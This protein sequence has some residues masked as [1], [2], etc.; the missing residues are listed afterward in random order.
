MKHPVLDRILILLCAAAAFAGAAGIVLLLFG[1]LSMD[2]VIAF[3]DKAALRI[4][5]FRLVSWDIALRED[6]EPV[7]I[8]ANFYD[9]E[10]DFHQ[11]NNGPLFGEDTEAI[12]R[13]VFKQ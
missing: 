8:E 2:R 4:P 13:E 9:G 3:V 10:I 11:L 7:L 5:H 1:Y 12:L 6:G